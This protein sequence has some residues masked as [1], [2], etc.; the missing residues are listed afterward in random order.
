MVYVIMLVYL[1][2]SFLYLKDGDVKR[3][4]SQIIHS[5]TNQGKSQ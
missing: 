5:N 2:H 4:S 1:K 3:S